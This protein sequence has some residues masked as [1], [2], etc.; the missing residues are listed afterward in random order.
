MNWK[1]NMKKITSMSKIILILFLL[2]PIL[3]AQ[4]GTNMQFTIGEKAPDFRLR[5]ETGTYRTLAEYA[6]K[7]I[8][9]YF[10]PKDDTPGCTKEACS[11]RD[12]YRE[13]QAQEI[14]ILGISYD[15]PSSH[16]KF[17]EKYN[18]PFS[19]LSDEK[20][21][22]AKAYGAYKG[23]GQSLTPLRITFLID[24]MG[25]IVHIFEKVN[26]S[27]HARD[28]LDAFAAHTQSKK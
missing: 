22:A 16:K 24:E 6:G 25:K 26:V 7:K 1:A 5:D 10:Y 12:G 3:D 20:K 21:E 23:I 18:L 8:V 19:L 17:K 14:V 2:S 27:E 11:F 28:V 4:E 15:S 13:I 9:V